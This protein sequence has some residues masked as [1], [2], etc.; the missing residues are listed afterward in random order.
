M[1]NAKEGLPSFV[2]DYFIFLSNNNPLKMFSL[3]AIYI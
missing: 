1:Q 3:F 2:F